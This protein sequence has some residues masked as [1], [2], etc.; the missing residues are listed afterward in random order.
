M[1]LTYSRYLQLDGL[2][3]L[4]QPLSDDPEHDEMLFIIT[5]QVYELWFKQMIH[6]LEALQEAFEKNHLSDIFRCLKRVLSILKVLVAQMDILETMSPVS[7]NSFR[8]RLEAASGFQSAQFRVVEFLLGARNPQVFA[9]YPDGLAERE[10]L[11]TLLTLPSIWD[12][13]L[14]FLQ[15]NGY[16]IPKELQSRDLS[17]PVPSNDKVQQHLINIYRV[18]PL[19]S[20]I[21][22]LLIDFDEGLQEWRYRH[23]KMVERTIGTK[24]GTGG[25]PG[26][27]YLMSTMLKPLFPD[28][29][30]IRKEL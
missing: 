17:Q 24:Q 29:W 5:H 13:F 15:D 20:Q 22:E 3:S 18:N 2:L 19:L 14:H 7:F 27:E 8:A 23:I 6:E 28:L 11:E 30:A 1:P 12:S 26:A 16:E 25:S 21:C 9:H 10:R 4:Q